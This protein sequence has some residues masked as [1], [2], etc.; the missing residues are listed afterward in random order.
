MDAFE[1]C[2]RVGFGW[3]LPSIE[4]LK[5]LAALVPEV[6]HG[7]YW[8]STEDSNDTAYCLSRGVEQK[9]PEK[10]QSGVIAVRRF[11]YDG[12]AL[13]SVGTLYKQENGVAYEYKILASTYEYGTVK[14]SSFTRLIRFTEKTVLS[15]IHLF[16]GL[17]F[18]HD[19]LVN[20]P[21]KLNIERARDLNYYES[22]DTMKVVKRPPDMPT[23]E[24]RSVAGSAENF[25]YGAYQFAARYEYEDGEMSAISPYSGMA[26][27]F[28]NAGSDGEV[29]K[30]FLFMGAVIIGGVP[31]EGKGTLT[32]MWSE[33]GIKFKRDNLT[34]FDEYD[35]KAKIINQVIV[36]SMCTSR[37]GKVIVGVLG[38]SAV[39]VEDNEVR[40]IDSGKSSHFVSAC[41]NE[42]GSNILFLRTWGEGKDDCPFYI[43]KCVEVNGKKKLE[44]VWQ[45]DKGGLSNYKGGPYTMQRGL[46][47]NASGNVCYAL[48]RYA[49]CKS[50][51]YG[52]EGSWSEIATK[53]VIFPGSDV[54]NAAVCLQHVCCSADGQ[55]VYVSCG[56]H[57][58]VSRDEGKTWKAIFNKV[59]GYNIFSIDCSA[60]GRVI[61]RSG[62]L[63]VSEN[64]G[65]SWNTEMS[66]V[67]VP[68]VEIPYAGYMT[69]GIAVSE[70][71][72]CIF[73][74]E[75]IVINGS[76]GYFYPFCSKDKGHVFRYI[77]ANRGGVSSSYWSNMF[78]GAKALPDSSL[79]DTTV[80]NRTT[81]VA[82]RYNT[83][84]RHVKAIHLLMKNGANMYKIH[85]IE[86]A[87]LPDHSIQEYVFRNQGLYA[88]VAQKDVVKLYDNVPLRVRTS[89]VIQ[90]ALMYGGYVDG[91][92]S[93][94]KVDATIEIANET[95]SRGDFSLKCNTIQ[96]YGLVYYDAFGRCGPVQ[97]IG[98]VYTD[99]VTKDIK[100]PKRVARITLRHQAPDWAVKYKFVRKSMAIRFDGI[101][102]F[103][104]AC[105]YNHKIYLEITTRTNIVASV[106]D[107]LELVYESS[108]KGKKALGTEF[109][110]I[111]Y[112]DVISD[113][114]T[115]VTLPRGRYMVIECPTQ[116]GFTQTE[117][118]TKA[119]LFLSGYF[120]LVY[121]E[122][123][124]DSK[125]YQETPFEFAV[126]NRLHQGNVK[127]QD[128]AGEAV[129]R[130]DGD[131]DVILLDNPNREINRLLGGAI[132]TTLGR[133]N[134]LVD[135]FKETDRQA[136]LCVSEPYVDDT[137][138]N[139][140]SSFNLS[141][142][143]YKDLDDG[144]GEIELIDGY[145]TDVDVYQR[146]RCSQV[147]YRKNILATASGDSQVAQSQDIFGEQLMYGGDWGM[148]DFRTY[149]RWGNA[150]YFVDAKRGVVLRKEAG[151]LAPVSD[152]GMKDWFFDRLRAGSELMGCF[153]PRHGAYLLALGDGI[154]NFLEAAKGWSSFFTIQP[155][156]L[157]NTPRGVF[158]FK[159]GKL[160]RHDTRENECRLY[161]QDADVVVEVVCNEWA[162]VVKVFNALLLETTDKPYRVEFRSGGQQT[163]I[164][165]SFFEKQEGL[166]LSCIPMGAG[167]GDYVTA[168]VCMQ[169]Y[170]GSMIPLAN[171]D[172]T[173]VH[174]GDKVYVV[175]MGADEVMG[176][177]LS[178]GVVQEV[179]SNYLT[180]DKQVDVKAGS[181]IICTD[182]SQINGEPQR[183]RHLGIKLFFR[184]QGKLLVRSI[185][186]DVD[187]SKI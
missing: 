31:D 153:D 114:K 66:Y 48:K 109:Q 28:P 15:G 21:Y 136:G 173:A 129:C 36:K 55:V 96:T 79:S 102:G 78:F 187:E 154:I 4:E 64:F 72:D 168:G 92:D 9:L 160:Y 69:C 93:A 84:D 63:A 49:L 158:S 161:G 116:E 124:E 117:V 133:T 50:N 115:E 170:L 34:L 39:V 75:A 70:S 148:S 166:Y 126:M 143:N 17:L 13:A 27:N 135:N 3:Y 80:T 38:T 2:A 45:G 177:P 56:N 100:A 89:K 47:M 54:G 62:N 157:V 146:E 111:G 144:H 14:Q 5:V 40:C 53:V 184:P 155:D 71:G 140:L 68:S 127:N 175:Q 32:K 87:G 178:A 44:V 172:S 151:S 121:H 183:G 152:W 61:A 65:T 171:P 81:E 91:H 85:R 77:D 35:G 149:A 113:N 42:M 105:V 26:F 142:V 119:S 110:V 52:K 88:Q 164:D 165:D 41:V 18:F 107:M 46:A 120:Y 90:N 103:D 37:D 137:G 19:R 174:V 30:D 95:G 179:G 156:R 130:L 123:V 57:L 106:G 51:D 25:R 97:L 132:F 12:N 67:R 16:K 162:D 185:Q 163:V 43:Y 6:N 1:A 139:G 112:E 150:R 159:D 128:R 24:A 118:E 122:K 182:A 8:S 180:L 181:L 33:D 23:I 86:K 20:E 83:G 176:E 60:D 76:T 29:Q 101:H 167:E 134:A 108:E 141:L 82:I 125:V 145:G 131:G 94:V 74:T 99:K 73:M 58:S 138:Y 22:E 186:V 147:Q 98:D 10:N 169:P 104:N 11:R 59:S 7:A